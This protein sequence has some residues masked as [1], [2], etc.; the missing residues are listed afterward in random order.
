MSF[1]WVARVCF[2][3]RAWMGFELVALGEAI[4]E[5]VIITGVVT[6]IENPRT[7]RIRD[8]FEDAPDPAEMV[9]HRRVR[10]NGAQQPDPMM[11]KL[12]RVRG[13]VGCFKGT[14]LRAS[15]QSTNGRKL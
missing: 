7:Y 11:G 12:A 3:V 15:L 5:P 1:L 8:A 2:G 13:T 6:R 4:G 10:P 9:V 14:F